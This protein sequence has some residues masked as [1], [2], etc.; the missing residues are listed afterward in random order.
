MLFD[1]SDEAE[2]VIGK[3]THERKNHVK[4]VPGYDLTA[5]TSR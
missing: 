3:S 5:G 1:E 4:M 2:P